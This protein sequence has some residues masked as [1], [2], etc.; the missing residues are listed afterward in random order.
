GRKIPAKAVHSSVFVFVLNMA[1]SAAKYQEFL[2]DVRA[3]AKE[4]GV[5]GFLYRLPPHPERKGE[6]KYWFEVLFFPA[7]DLAIS[8][9]WTLREGLEKTWRDLWNRLG[10]E[11]G[12]EEF[13]GK[14][15]AND[16]VKSKPATF[17][18]LKGPE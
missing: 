14:A 13:G 15:A 3:G 10:P 7:K 16:R 8:L 6:C 5:E 2:T 17:Q 18:Y 11:Y 12:Y 4:N 1:G 9:K